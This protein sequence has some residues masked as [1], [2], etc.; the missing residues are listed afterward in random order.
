ML[1][2]LLFLLEVL[3][4][5]FDVGRTQKLSHRRACFEFRT[6]PTPVL[7]NCIV[8]RVYGVKTFATEF[9]VPLRD[10]QPASLRL[11]ATTWAHAHNVHGGAPPFFATSGA[12]VS[13]VTWLALAGQHAE[14]FAARAR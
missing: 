12:R 1:A 5:R 4:S 2:W 13:A 6:S 3:R 7:S 10:W 14:R 9:R 11:S 8:L